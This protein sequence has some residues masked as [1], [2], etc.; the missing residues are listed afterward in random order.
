MNLN[1]LNANNETNQY[2]NLLN[3]F[4]FFISNDKISR[5]ISGTLLDHAITNFHEK[6]KIVNSTIDNDFSDHNIIL[7]EIHL[8]SKCESQTYYKKFTDF[9]LFKINLIKNLECEAN[10][11]SNVNSYCNFISD[12]LTTALIG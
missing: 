7:S 5:P 1:V 8:S 12:S 4:G 3:S 11:S 6:F 10:H 9:E 2:R